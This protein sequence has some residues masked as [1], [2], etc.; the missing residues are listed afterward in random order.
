MISIPMILAII[1][2]ILAIV[3]YFVPAP[4]NRDASLAFTIVSLGCVILYLYGG[5]RL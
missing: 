2:V 4:W 1:F 3:L 5:H